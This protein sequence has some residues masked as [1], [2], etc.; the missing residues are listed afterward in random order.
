M[1]AA[2]VDGCCYGAHVSS[3]GGIWTA[4]DRGK[5]IGCD[6][7]QV[8]TQ[9]PRMWRP[10]DHTPEA[11]ARFRERRVE[12]GI[13]SVVCHA[14][15]LV[16]LASPDR[17]IRKKSSTAMRA[18]LEAADAIGA[19]GVIF[20]VGSHLGDGL[21]VGLRRSRPRAAVAAR[22][23]DRRPLAADGELRGHGRDDRAFDG[24]AGADLR[25]ARPPPP[26]RDLP[27]LVPLVRVGS[28]RH[29]PGG[30]RRRRRRARRADRARPASLSARE[31]LA[32]AARLEPRP[33][34]VRRTRADGRRAAHLPLPPCVP[35]AAG[36]PRDAGAGRRRAGRGRAGATAGAA[37]G[38]GGA[39]GASEG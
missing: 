28:R 15:Y 24:R 6:A 38:E 20:H 12:A 37:R 9:S 2:S 4:V 30:A 27:R 3:A 10:T 33:P 21:T 18:S 7:I 16:N 5:E 13:E 34:R 29:R 8:F 26:A 32:D 11:V 19:E 1:R 22:A 35:G 36:D 17:E 31:R 25:Q 39:Q 23:D 14:L